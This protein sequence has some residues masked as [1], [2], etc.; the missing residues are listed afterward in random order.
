MN[1]RAATLDDLPTLARLLG[2]LNENV[3]PHRPSAIAQRSRRWR[4]TRGSGC[5]SS[6]VTVR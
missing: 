3:P 5:L 6:S 1:I 2:Q 4:P